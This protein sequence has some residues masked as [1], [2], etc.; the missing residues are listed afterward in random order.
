M[1]IS[2]YVYR[3]IYMYVCSYAILYSLYGLHL[4]FICCILML[5]LEEEIKVSINQAV[6][7]WDVLSNILMQIKKKA[8]PLIR[9]Y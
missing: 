1:C 2:L 6:L 5:S 8:I 4:V 7:Q 3:C 9:L